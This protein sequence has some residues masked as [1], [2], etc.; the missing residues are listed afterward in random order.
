MVWIVCGLGNPG[1]KYEQT[2]HNV[3]F[4]TVDE[5]CEQLG[6]R[7]SSKFS[8]LIAE[9]SASSAANAQKVVLVKPQ[10]FMNLSGGPLKQVTNY[11]KIPADNLVVVHDD[12]DLQ[13]GAIKVKFGGGDA[14]H[15]GL[16]SITKSFGTNEYYRIRL[17]VGRLSE[18]AAVSSYVLGQFS[19]AQKNELPEFL[20]RAVDASLGLIMTTLEEV[21]RKFHSKS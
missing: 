20:A 2:P 14:G 4:R 12:I 11:F 13:F 16:R 21:Q 18:S 5:L 17:G 6:A 10:Q 19:K 1:T 8:A 9:A 7:W 3:G 15:N